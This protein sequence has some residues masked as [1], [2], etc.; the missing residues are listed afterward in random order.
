MSD[1]Y[2][3]D[4]IIAIYHFINESDSENKEQLIEYLD[5]ISVE[6]GQLSEL[7]F[8]NMENKY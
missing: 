2:I 6:I 3:K 8:T 5:D 1:M 4:K 7:V